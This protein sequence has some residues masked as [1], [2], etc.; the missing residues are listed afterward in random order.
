VL[1]FRETVASA[2]CIVLTD[3]T[4]LRVKLPSRRLEFTAPQADLRNQEDPDR[5]RRSTAEAG[6]GAPVHRR[7]SA[8][9]LGG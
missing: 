8:A 2:R 6:L 1:E 4:G 3:D 7:V 9:P 5:E